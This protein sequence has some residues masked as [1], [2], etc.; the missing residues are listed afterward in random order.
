VNQPTTSYESL[1]KWIKPSD[2]EQ[3]TWIRN[4]LS[5]KIPGQ[6]LL[7]SLI[8]QDVDSEWLKTILST[9]LGFADRRELIKQMRGAWHQRM[10]RKKKGKQVSFQLPAEIVAKLSSIARDRKRSK[11]QTLRQIIG[12]A[13][14]QNQLDN[15]R[16]RKLKSD[17]QKLDKSK[18][19]ALA[20]HERLILTLLETLAEEVSQRVCYEVA[21]G[22]IPANELSE[23]TASPEYQEALTKRSKEID[24]QLADLILIKAKYR[25]LTKLIQDSI[26]R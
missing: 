15:K 4:Y 23:H 24:E 18:A 8:S 17:I 20:V 22:S 11:T 13:A 7:D 25:S 6:P 21:M 10:Y 26:A 9:H 1:L 3:A 2:T 16:I 19:A 12:E 5:K 14:K